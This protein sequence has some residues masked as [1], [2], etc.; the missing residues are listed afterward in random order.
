VI[1][2][3]DLEIDLASHTVTKSGAEVHLTKTEFKLLALLARNV[4]KV[5]THTQLLR[6]VWGPE[7]EDELHY[8][9]VY[10]QQLRAKIESDPT[11]PR[12]LTTETG[13]G[14]RLRSE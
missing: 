4:G 9:R 10:S 12:I 1:K 2:V 7:Y 8:L 6:E 14:Y 13:V 3:Q 11:Q 5:L